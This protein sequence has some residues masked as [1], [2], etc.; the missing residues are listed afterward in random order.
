LSSL[1]LPAGL[2]GRRLREITDDRPVVLQQVSLVRNDVYYLAPDFVRGRAGAIYASYLIRH[3]GYVAGN[4]VESWPIMFDQLF[5]HNFRFNDAL[6]MFQF[7][8]LL[9]VVDWIEIRL[10]VLTSLVLLITALLFVRGGSSDFVLSLGVLLALAGGTNAV[11]GFHGDLW[12][13]SEMG[14]HAWIGSTFLRIGSAI[15]FL[16]SFQ[17]LTGRFRRA[18]PST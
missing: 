5:G 4:I 2:R 16:R 11:I 18:L 13:V 15:V 1:K 14:R 17:M 10:F 12:E 9:S 3:P 7:S 6:S 8:K